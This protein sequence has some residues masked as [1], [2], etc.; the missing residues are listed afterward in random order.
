VVAIGVNVT[1]TFIGIAQLNLLDLAVL[2]AVDKASRR[3]T[4]GN[5]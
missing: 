2:V 1:K 5:I 4:M 3:I